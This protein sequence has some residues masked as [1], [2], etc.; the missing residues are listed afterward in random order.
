MSVSNIHTNMDY[1]VHPLKMGE[2][3]HGT[4]MSSAV[5][6]DSKLWI[7]K[8]I[9]SHRALSELSI[10]APLN[11]APAFSSTTFP[12]MLHTLSQTLASVDR[13]QQ[14]QRG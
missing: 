1:E 11:F 2:R 5:P 12:G 10:Y 8:H 7:D 4:T 9:G 6:Y 3:R 13:P 14:H